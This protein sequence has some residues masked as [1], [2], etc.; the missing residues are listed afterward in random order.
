M[1]KICLQ[2]GK[3][4]RI[5]FYSEGEFFRLTDEFPAF[6]VTY[7]TFFWKI[8]EANLEKLP[9][10]V[11]EYFTIGI[12]KEAYSLKWISAKT[13]MNVHH[14]L[15]HSCKCVDEKFPNDLVQHKTDFDRSCIT[16]STRET[17]ARRKN[18][19]AQ[20]RQ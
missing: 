14:R 18:K 7:D 4:N 8:P 15:E 13:E 19:P 1:D 17:I 12:K 10:L 9:R 5:Q 20:K 11:S 2:K 6:A 3:I 16:Q